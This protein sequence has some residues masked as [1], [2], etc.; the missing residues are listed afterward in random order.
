MK[1]YIKLLRVKHYIKNLLIFVP[2][3]FGGVFFD[4]SKLTA[5]MVGFWCFSFISSA[6][7]IL[8]DLKDIEK[9]RKHPIKKNRPLASGQIKPRVAIV[10]MSLCIGVSCVLSFYLD[11][12]R[13]FVLL[14]S[15]LGLNE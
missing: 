12:F 15:Y 2:M 4:F 9:D 14:I 8:N 6:I 1:K 3:F 7:Y 13:S 5:G 10:I 11:N